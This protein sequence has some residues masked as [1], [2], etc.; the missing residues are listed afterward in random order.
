[1]GIAKANPRAVLAVGSTENAVAP[2]MT[3]VASPMGLA[4]AKP[5]V[6]P[7]LVRN[8]GH[9][10]DVVASQLALVA[11]PIGMAIVKPTA[12]PMVIM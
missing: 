3:S 10:N 8:V 9:Q 7:T 2:R 1:M 12:E 6:A 4:T 5:T 11:L